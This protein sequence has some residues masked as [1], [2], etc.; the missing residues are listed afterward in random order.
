MGFGQVVRKLLLLNVRNGIDVLK[1]PLAIPVLVEQ[2]IVAPQFLGHLADQVQV[3]FGQESGNGNVAALLK[4]LDP[5]KPFPGHNS[6]HESEVEAPHHDDSKNDGERGHNNPVLNIV[7]TEDGA[8][9]T[10][11]DAVIVLVLNAVFVCLT[12]V[13]VTVILFQERV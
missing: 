3:L 8:V 4:D 9:H 13:C 7:D 12:E 6:F 5:D 10:V 1:L 2:V 11:I